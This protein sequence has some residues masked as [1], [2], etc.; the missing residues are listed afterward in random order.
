MRCLRHKI[1]LN[2][3]FSLLTANLDWVLSDATQV[4]TEWRKQ[5]GQEGSMDGSLSI[6][7][8]DKCMIFS[9][10]GKIFN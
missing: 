2:L 1:H 8:W 9:F 5:Y 7:A 6:L 10:H 3:F 4:K